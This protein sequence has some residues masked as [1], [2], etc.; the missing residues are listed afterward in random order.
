[1]YGKR[2]YPQEERICCHKRLEQYLKGLSIATIG[3]RNLMKINTLAD[4]TVLQTDNIFLNSY[5]QSTH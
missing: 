4:K 2:D 5:Q 1:M 3:M